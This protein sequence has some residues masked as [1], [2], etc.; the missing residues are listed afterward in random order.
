[1]TELMKAA[2]FKG[3]GKISIEHMPKPKLKRAR[4]L[5]ADGEVLVFDKDDT[6]L[7]EVLLTG[8]C[9]TDA[10]ILAVPQKYPA[11]VGTI[12]GHEVVGR[13]VEVGARVERVRVGDLVVVDEHISCGHCEFCRKGYFNRCEEIASMGMTTNGGFVQYMLV[14]AKQVYRVP[15]DLD[16]YKA[17]LFEPLYCAVHAVS[18]LDFSLNSEVL[19]LGGG[20]LGCC[21]V[22]IFRL[23]GLDKIIVSEPEPY[24]QDFVKL[25]GAA[26]VVHPTDLEDVIDSIAPRGVDIVIDA[27]GVAEAVK[28]AITL[29]KRCGQISLFGQ[30]DDF[31]K[32]E[33]SFVEANRKELKITG[34]DA[35]SPFVADE[36]IGYITRA[37]FRLHNIV[38]HELSLGEILTALELMHTRKAMK[39]VINPWKEG[40][41]K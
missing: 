27:S 38:T 32:T 17:V 34:A 13:I 16:L 25:L 9:G 3:G 4:F 19:I 20:P 31:S 2:V 29:T 35:A 8:F 28:E 5:K 33:F 6:V 41:Q 11:R 14:P 23:N 36:T 22:E 37:D 12:P 7:I 24:R 21:F 39:V 40:G 10:H 15:Y 30:Q 26:K 1:M 18:K